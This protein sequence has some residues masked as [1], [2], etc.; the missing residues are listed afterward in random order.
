MPKA[1]SKYTTSPRGCPILRSSCQVTRSTNSPETK[2]FFVSISSDFVNGSW[3]T[4]RK[5]GN[6]LAH[7]HKSKMVSR[8]LALGFVAYF[9]VHQTSAQTQKLRPPEKLTDGI[10]LPVKDSFLKLEVCTDSVIHV[11]F[12]KDR[13]FSLDPRS[14]TRLH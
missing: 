7:Y 2:D 4:E 11:T 12:S 9:V 8:V 1:R 6:N 14:H 10:V 13:I 3:S 5:H